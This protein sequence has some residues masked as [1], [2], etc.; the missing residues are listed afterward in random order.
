VN[1]AWLSADLGFE[2]VG[3]LEVGFELL[4]SDNGTARFVTPLAT[5]HKFNGFADVFLDNGRPTGLRDFF[6]SIDP[7]LPWGMKGKFINHKFWDDDSGDNFGDEYDFVVSK[8]LMYGF[9]V[10]GV[11]AMYDASQHG[12]SLGRENLWRTTLDLEFK[13]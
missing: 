2:P 13:Y 8:Q 9:S 1:Y 4:G 6:V 10:L 3:K 12:Q 5:A 7:N 11:A